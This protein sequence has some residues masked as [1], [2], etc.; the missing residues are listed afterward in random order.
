MILQLDP[1]SPI[2]PYEQLR[3]QITTMVATGVLARGA[4]LPPIR[5]LAGDLGVATATIA[6]AFR[7]LERDQIITTRGRHGTFV[8]DAPARVAATERDQRLATAARRF[9][10]QARQLGVDPDDALR[11]ARRALETLAPQLAP[12]ADQA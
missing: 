5:Q 8:L 4:R 9:A 2:P 3:T 6:R 10:V 11:Q 7:E 1:E 12:Q